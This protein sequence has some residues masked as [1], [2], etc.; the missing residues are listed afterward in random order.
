[1]LTCGCWGDPHCHTFDDAKFDFMG[2]CKYDLVSTDCFGSQL[3]AGLVPF[4]V[5]QR[6]EKRPRRNGVS[7]IQYVEVNVYGNQYRLMKRQKG[8]N[9]PSLSINGLPSYQPLSDKGIRVYKAGRNLIF[10]ADF[11]LTITWDG[12][13]RAEVALCDAY[14]KF[15]CGLCGNADGK[16]LNK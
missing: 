4:N 11:G 15:T 2:A 10:S 6:Q 8:S 9:I 13:H 1:M 12:R 5:R 3:P 16:Y 14:A 7:F